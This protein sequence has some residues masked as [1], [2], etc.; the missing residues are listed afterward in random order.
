MGIEFDPDFI[1][2]DNWDASFA[3]ASNAG[4]KSTI[5]MCYFHVIYNIKKHYKHTL[6]K[7]E[8]FELRGIL[9]DIHLSRNQKERDAEWLKFKDRYEPKKAKRAKKGEKKGVYEYVRDSWYES[10]F[11]KWMIYHTPPGFANTNSNIESFNA[12]IKRDFFTRKRLSVLGCALKLEEVIKYYSS[13]D[14]EFNK[15]PKFN[16]DLQ[17]KAS[18]TSASDFVSFGKL[19]K[20]KSSS[21]K[22]DYHII[23]PE[24][25]S[26]SCSIYLKK[27][28]CNH[29]L[30]YSNLF[31]LC[32]FGK[33][34]SGKA[35]KFF[36]KTKRG[37]L[38]GR[39]PNAKKALNKS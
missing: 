37:R 32:W 35:T 21:E 4:L 36:V 10:R 11:N 9:T 15:Y 29:S 31:S 16:G 13:S 27:A 38:A 5:I 26:C 30:A 1:M 23:N 6:T 8:W 34:F 22:Y 7:E 25:K 3:G 28:I 24:K 17:K 20:L 12:T 14:I 2:Q 33:S 19:F 18:L 39:E